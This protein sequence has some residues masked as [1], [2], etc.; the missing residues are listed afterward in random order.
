MR[1]VLIF[2]YD[3]TV[4]E[5]LKI[6][7]PAVEKAID[8]LEGPCG[9][10]V[11]RP[12]PERMAGWLGMNMDDM[13]ADFMPGLDEETK[14][15]AALMVGK[16]MLE[17]TAAHEAGWYEGME[18][19][20]DLLKE[21]GYSM[22]VL[23]NCGIPYA[24]TQWETFGMDRWF[25]AFFQCE[26]FDNAPKE[27][28]MKAIASDYEKAVGETPVS[29]KESAAG[30]GSEGFLVIGDRNSDLGAAKAI[31]A[32]FIGCVYGYGKYGELDEA[33]VSAGSAKDIRTAVSV[34][35]GKQ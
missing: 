22:A 6:Y 20:L 7:M 26:S 16:I 9:L 28:I 29:R 23:S 33:D 24:K 35:C 17:R 19:C 31:T 30:A 32:P 1:P 25:D 14:M 34:L 8:W 11:E 4:N 21:Q 27:D 13:W 10:E 12:E 18:E 15:K 5:T 2:D 3:G